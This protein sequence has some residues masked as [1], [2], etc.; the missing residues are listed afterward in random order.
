MGALITCTCI[1]YLSAPYI[2]VFSRNLGMLLGAILL[3]LL[4]LTDCANLGFLI[5]VGSL[6]GGISLSCLK[7][8]LASKA[9]IPSS[10]ITENV[11]HKNQAQGEAGSFSQRNVALVRAFSL[12]FTAPVYFHWI[13]YLYT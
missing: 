13:R 8:S 3:A 9:E 11:T 6:V 7:R 12:I 1:A 2:T 4:I 10:A 5:G